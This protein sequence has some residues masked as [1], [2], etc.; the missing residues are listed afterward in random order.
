M[1]PSSNTPPPFM[2][3]SPPLWAARHLEAE[4]EGGE[5]DHLL[6]G[7]DRLVVGAGDG[8]LDDVAPRLRG[9]LDG[10]IQDE[11][12]R[13]LGVEAARPAPLRGCVR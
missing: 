4:D 5:R 13:A 2:Q 1:S 7:G 8:R 11:L 12:R 9:G 3:D 6:G 10:G